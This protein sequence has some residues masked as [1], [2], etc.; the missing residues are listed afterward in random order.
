MK[1]CLIM[2]TPAYLFFTDI[3]LWTHYI[4]L[5]M[6]WDEQHS[7]IPSHY[8]PKYLHKAISDKTQKLPARAWEVVKVF[9][10]DFL[11]I[12]IAMEAEGVQIFNE[13]WTSIEINLRY[14]N[15]PIQINWK[16]HLQKLEV[17]R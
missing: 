4:D 5:L 3:L 8:L 2:Y 1:N 13:I 6:W 15:M 16:F 7:C 10:I 11:K 12:S 14:K 9:S 17:F